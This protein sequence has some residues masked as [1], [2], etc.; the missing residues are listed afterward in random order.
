MSLD[1]AKFLDLDSTKKKTEKTE[2]NKFLKVDTDLVVS[3]NSGLNWLIK[4]T[5]QD[6][7]LESRRSALSSSA[8]MLASQPLISTSL[9]CC[10]I[11]RRLSCPEPA[12]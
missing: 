8:K 5:L 6:F 2:K 3:V 7:R 1:H 10:S 11:N 9:E 4:L 12:F